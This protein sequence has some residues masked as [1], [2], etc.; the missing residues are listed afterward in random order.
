MSGVPPSRDKCHSMKQRPEQEQHFLVFLS[1]RQCLLPSDPTLT[2]ATSR[3]GKAEQQAQ[4]P[5]RRQRGFQLP[6]SGTAPSGVGS[7]KLSATHLRLW[8]EERGAVLVHLKPR[9]GSP[10]R[11]ATGQTRAAGPALLAPPLLP[12]AIG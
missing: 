12:R 11:G 5:G 8:L 2:T 4:L 6:A 9:G 1:H 10:G 3:R 7:P